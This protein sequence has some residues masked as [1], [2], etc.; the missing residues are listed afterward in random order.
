MGSLVL[1]GRSLGRREQ[2]A[3]VDDLDF[4]RRMLLDPHQPFSGVMA[5]AEY[6]VGSLEGFEVVSEE[7]AAGS[8]SGNVAGR[9][10][11]FS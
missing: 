4:F 5:V 1:T 2:A 7:G 9:W 6:G 10:E 8:K 3:V 11:T